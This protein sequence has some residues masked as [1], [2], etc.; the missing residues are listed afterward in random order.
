MK[1]L[2]RNIAVFLL[3]ALAVSCTNKPEKSQRVLDLEKSYQKAQEEVTN[4]DAKIRSASGDQGLTIQYNFE[5]ELAK[6]RAER[7][8]EQLKALSPDS[9][10]ASPEKK[11]DAAGH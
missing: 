6:S 2:R 4:F 8:K 3:W 7:I 1:P 5:K 10:L 11:S 9:V